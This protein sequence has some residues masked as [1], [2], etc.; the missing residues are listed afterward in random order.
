M[1]DNPED[2]AATVQAIRKWCALHKTEKHSN[3]DCQAQKETTNSNAKASK[4]RPKGAKEQRSVKPRKLKFKSNADKKKFLRSIEDTEGVSIASAS[5]DDEDVVE[6]SLLQLDD[7]CGD[8]QGEEEEEEGDLHILLMDPDLLLDDSDVNMDSVLL[9]PDQA[10]TDAL[11][12]A[13]RSIQLEGLEGERGQAGSPMSTKAEFSLSDTDL[14]NTSMNTPTVSIPPFKEEENP[15]SPQEYPTPDEILYPSRANEN[16]ANAL[17]APSPMQDYVLIDGTYY[18]PVPP[19]HNVVVAN[20]AIPVPTLT[21]AAVAAV[22]STPK[23]SEIPVEPVTNHVADEPEQSVPSNE[24]TACSAASRATACSATPGATA[25]PV[26]PGLADDPSVDPVPDFAA[27]QKPANRD[28]SQKDRKTRPR[29]P[30]SSSRCS[31]E[32]KTETANAP[33]G[34]DSHDASNTKRVRG[35]GRGKAKDQANAP[36]ITP[37]TPLSGIT[38]AKEN[39]RITIPEGSDRRIVEVIPSYP[40]NVAHLSKLE[41]EA[42]NRWDLQLSTLVKPEFVVKLPTEDP[43]EDSD[44]DLRTGEV[45]E[46][47]PWKAPLQF[48]FQSLSVLEDHQRFA[49]EVLRQEPNIWDRV[50]VENNPSLF[51]HAYFLDQQKINEVRT[52]ETIKIQQF[53]VKVTRQAPGKDVSASSKANRERLE[54]KFRVALTHMYQAFEEAFQFEQPELINDLRNHLV[55]PAITQITSLFASSRCRVCHRGRRMD[56]VWRIRRFET[57]LPY[58]A[59]VPLESYQRAEDYQANVLLDKTALIADGPLAD[60]Y[61]LGL[62]IEDK[63]LY[64][65]LGAAERESFDKELASLAQVNSLMK[66]SR[67]WENH[68]D[69]APAM[70]INLGHQSFQ[71]MRQ[72]RRMNLLPIAQMLLHRYHD[73]QEQLITRFG[74]TQDQD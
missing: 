40:A 45:R 16:A 15:F 46:S 38:T 41:N 70:E 34:F 28:R 53:N 51:Y 61:H 5:S 60:K 73:R 19:P 30:S 9:H 54:A 22:S 37:T 11:D 3:A 74:K 14:L 57:C 8:T 29:S 44:I 68:K 49:Q 35:I 42:S 6:Q 52:K 55:K 24:A 1:M 23:S 48:K 4:K 32:P 25:C 62:T 65:A 67:R 69:A 18:K 59:E 10:P 31:S 50:R 47:H 33:R 66:M 13:I 17:A 39:L 21:P 27:F 63:R 36:L 12:S 43:Q 20:S 58:L 7:A 71:K 56:A 2:E 26:V 72:L 64:L